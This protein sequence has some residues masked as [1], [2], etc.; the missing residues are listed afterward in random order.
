MT[1]LSC[2]PA[3]HATLV[4]DVYA[5]ARQPYVGL[6]FAEPAGTDPA[7]VLEV[8]RCAL[9]DVHLVRPLG[10]VARLAKAI[11]DGDITMIARCRRALSADEGAVQSYRDAMEIEM[12]IARGATGARRPVTVAGGPDY[13]HGGAR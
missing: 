2:S 5:F 12:L 9:C 13:P 4:G 10:I 1:N 7:D 3:L 8:R 6:R 11:V